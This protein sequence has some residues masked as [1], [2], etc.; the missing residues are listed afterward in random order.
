MYF[1]ERES[2]PKSVAEAEQLR[3]VLAF[4]EA[5]PKEQL[6]WTY[7]KPGD[8]ERAVREDLT[9]F[10]LAHA[11][12]APAAPQAS[13]P[14]RAETSP[15][16][17]VRLNMPLQPAY[18]A[19]RA[20]ELAAIDE[21]LGVADRA[22]VTQAI[23]GLGG[24]GK[25]QLAARYLHLYQDD[26]DIVAW[27][28][29]EDGGAKDLA[30]LADELCDLAEDMPVD[31]R[32]E[33]ALRDLASCGER[34]LLV[35]DNL[36]SPAQL[37]G[38][39]PS[40]GN[41]RVLVTTRDRTIDQFAPLLAVDVFDEPTAI[42][43]LLTRTGRPGEREAARRVAATVG[44]LPLALTHAGAYCAQGTS[45][46]DYLD[47]L[48]TLPPR[49]LFAKAPEVFYRETVASTWQ[50]SMRAAA[51]EAELATPMLEMA[52]LL[53]PDDIPR[54]L[55]D[56]LVEDDDPLALIE[57]AQALHRLSLAVVTPETVS[58]HRLLQ[59]VV[60]ASET[61]E[62]ERARR[63]VLDALAGALPDDPQDPGL[64][65]AFE[66]VVP[67]VLVLGDTVEE[68]A[69]DAAELVR[70]LNAAGNYLLGAGGVQRAVEATTAIRE[71]AER[72]LG[73]EHVRTLSAR[74]TLAFALWSAGRTSDAITIE[75]QVLADRERLL[76]T[77]HLD[78]LTARANLAGSYWSA[79]RTTHAIALF[80]KI[81]ADRERLLGTDH[82]STLTSRANLATCY[83]SAGR[84][85]DA[86]TLREQN[87]AD[88]ER[89]LGTDHPNT[90]NARANLAA[91]YWSAGRAADSIPI[92]ENVLADRER[93][94]GTDHPDTLRARANLA[95][96]Y[97]SAGRT[98]DVLTLREQVL[99]D[100]ERV[101]G[102]DHPETLSARGNL[103]NSYWSTG[104]RADA[105]SLFTQ[106]LAD[107][108]R[109]LGTDH[110]DTVF[111]R[112]NLAAAYRAEGRVG[113][114][115]ALEAAGA[116]EDAE[117][118]ADVS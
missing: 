107:R 76:G 67:H 109:L 15:R 29:A 111:S 30:A 108:E 59:R 106:T 33:H 20:P 66:E 96:S 64:W 28:A 36:T 85:T 40:S 13:A 88:W 79:G 82:P 14:A 114:A 16:R 81:L 26:Y 57:A 84:T 41:G 70:L 6:W 58:V 12:P 3:K 60:R 72:L 86:L 103:A 63:L 68:P 45:L 1:C 51:A 65:P 93:L 2:R 75:K 46:D 49:A 7:E 22:V 89:L 9:A 52:S 38:C 113:E 42:D 77:D 118:G 92:E 61:F 27:I 115:E 24:V 53:A 78:T 71:H 69:E 99:A 35:L 112:A 25:S 80:E 101:L 74:G 5:M 110:R 95:A 8:F 17:R 50:V 83:A 94:L 10:V 104:R 48:Q 54:S 87:V 47:L 117:P 32:A 31:K 43:Y 97:Q 37:A 19:G 56:V 100:H 62:G 102:T 23:G 18:F 39:C 116:S 21:A 4:R 105:L 73:A 11:A 91:S 98:T 55:F 90:L 44:R 34:W